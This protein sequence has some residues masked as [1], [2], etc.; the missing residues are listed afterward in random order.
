MSWQHFDRCDA[1]DSSSLEDCVEGCRS[2]GQDNCNLVWWQAETEPVESTTQGSCCKAKWSDDKRAII[3]GEELGAGENFLNH[4]AINLN[5]DNGDVRFTDL[6]YRN[7]ASLSSPGWN[8]DATGSQ[9]HC[10]CPEANTY[11]LNLK[12][13]CEYNRELD[14]CENTAEDR[15][16]RVDPSGNYCKY[17]EFKYGLNRDELILEDTPLRERQGNVAY[18]FRTYD[19]W[20][21][22]PSDLTV[23]LSQASGGADRPVQDIINT[24]RADMS[25]DAGENNWWEN[26]MGGGEYWEDAG[27][28]RNKIILMNNVKFKDP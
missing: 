21:D 17:N 18:H 24:W 12:D 3:S 22:I 19:E 8:A 13:K 27:H 23:P 5:T 15:C 14:N 9:A 6:V 25:L 1:G 16:R 2:A 28:D 26:N 7:Q 11:G 20:W 10:S 4:D